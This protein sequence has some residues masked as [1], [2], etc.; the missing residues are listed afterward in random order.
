PSKRNARRAFSGQRIV[1]RCLL[2]RSRLW[3]GGLQRQPVVY[4]KVGSDAP[5]RFVSENRP[6]AVSDINPQ[7][8]RDAWFSSRLRPVGGPPETIH[9]DGNAQTVVVIRG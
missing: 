5:K 8:L 9:L 7:P 4:F 2:E 3:W 1:Q 6:N